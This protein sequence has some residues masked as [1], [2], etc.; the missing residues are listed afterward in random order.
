MFYNVLKVKDLVD[1]DGEM[2]DKNVLMESEHGALTAIAL[3]KNEIMDTHTSTCDSAVLVIDG[4]I[5]MHFDAQQFTVDKGEILMFKK[6]EQHK[7]L[8]KKDS[9]FLLIKI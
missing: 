2:F 5:E 4:E 3:K 7:V 6:D 9:K 1:L 8:A